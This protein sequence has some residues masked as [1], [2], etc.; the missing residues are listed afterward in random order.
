MN[1]KEFIKALKTMA[2][3][4]VIDEDYIFASMEQALIT[5]YK[6]NFHSKSNVKVEI[7]K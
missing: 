3:E 2:K 7:N 4:S 1:G 5:A 6:K